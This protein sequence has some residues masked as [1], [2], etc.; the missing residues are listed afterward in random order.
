MSSENTPAADLTSV[1]AVSWD[2]IPES[3]V[4]ELTPNGNLQQVEFRLLHN[5]AAR[6]LGRASARISNI[7]CSLMTS[8]KNVATV[9]VCMVPSSTGSTHAPSKIADVLACRPCILHSGPHY[10][11]TSGSPSF[12][13]GVSNILKGTT[14]S[15][16]AGSPPHLYFAS[17]STK[18]KDGTPSSDPIYLS[19]SYDI[20]LH[21][22]DWMPRF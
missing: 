3:D 7:S 1:S 16:L 14:T 8:T 19:I 21:G 18:F 10:S 11:P 13:P 17:I 5:C 9:A 6:L 2:K 12:L 15:I 20:E 22:Y 4:V